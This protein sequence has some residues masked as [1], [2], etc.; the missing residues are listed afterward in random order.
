MKGQLAEG[1]EAVA[2]RLEQLALAEPQN[3]R[4]LLPLAQAHLRLSNTEQAMNVLAR[5]LALDPN[6]SEA[7]D[8]LSDLCTAGT[9]PKDIS[10]SAI[11]RLIALYPDIIALHSVAIQLCRK[12]DERAERMKHLEAIYHHGVKGADFYTE[13]A[14]MLSYNGQYER[15]IEICEEALKAYP[16]SPG[17]Y[18]VR[19]SMHG[20]KG[21]N[22]QA[23]ACWA[24]VLELKPGDIQA[25]MLTGQIKLLLSDGKDGF[26]D[27]AA[28]RDR[29]FYQCMCNTSIPE[30][31]GQ[32]LAGK[33]L[34]LWCN[35]GI[36]DAFMFAGLLPWLFAQGAQVT[37]ALY[38]KLIPLFARS[39]PNVSV[40]PHTPETPQLAQQLF[41]RY[42][43]KCDFQLAMSQL[44]RLAL[45]HYTPSQHPPYLKADSPR[46]RTLREKYLALSQ[47]QRKK[48]VG[49][50]WHSKN[51]D[52]SSQRNI[53][54]SD[55]APLFSLPH[56]R[57]IS[58][59][60][61][62][63][64]GEMEAANRAFPG[65]LYADPD[66]DGF[67]NID[68]LAAQIAAC[69]EVVSIQNT[70]V[71]M[72]GAL[73]VKTTIMLSA[74]SDWRWGLVRTDSRWYTSVTVE[75]QETLMDWLP[76]LLRVARRL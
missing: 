5:L 24:K 32:P 70:T 31:S 6:H 23:L 39:F 64:A 20:V 7:I 13:Y 35:E 8:M 4:S 28:V 45:P 3:P 76:V 9:R 49:I 67:Q 16:D 52:N 50:S 72:A 36:G 33:H 46:V 47:G 69:D 12:V 15:C 40:V 58:L 17:P 53:P 29:V 34:L 74:A 57:Y 44:M 19:A 68:G 14:A 75:R 54:L 63:P 71:H 66:I 43:N 26:E 27:Y 38:P 42:T 10:G 41:D 1:W 65:A 59:Q 30:W 55:W 51:N 11:N 21:E 18:R 62:P 48:L 22:E 37:L 60:Y 2:K 25:R 56:V 61:S 73:G